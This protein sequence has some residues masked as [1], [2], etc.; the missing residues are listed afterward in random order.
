MFPKENVEEKDKGKNLKV[1]LVNNNGRIVKIC[2]PFFDVTPYDEN[3]RFLCAY[4]S[5][6]TERI[7][8]WVN[9][10]HPMKN[11]DLYK[12]SLDNCQHFVGEVVK[13]IN[14]EHCMFRSSYFFAALN[15]V[16]RHHRI[17]LPGA[18]ARSSS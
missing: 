9:D 8:R 6:N 15:W 13:F 10:E 1:E 5:C 2:E 12:I 18:I 7:E 17:N 11:E 3:M 14:Q 4:N 16:N